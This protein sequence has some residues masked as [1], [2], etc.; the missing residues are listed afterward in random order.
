MSAE[1]L[2]LLQFYPAIFK[3]GFEGCASDSARCKR[4]ILARIQ[5]CIISKKE[6]DFQ[7]L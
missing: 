2:S 6:P 4:S 1:E 3:A 7:P 5:K